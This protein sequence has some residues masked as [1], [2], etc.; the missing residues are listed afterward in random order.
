MSTTFRYCGSEGSACGRG[1]YVPP[2]SGSF[3]GGPWTLR[4][5]CLQWLTNITAG[6]KIAAFRLKAPSLKAIYYFTIS[7]CRLEANGGQSPPFLF[8]LSRGPP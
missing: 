6:F 2:A 5:K 7:I 3:V 8:P 4:S 1:S